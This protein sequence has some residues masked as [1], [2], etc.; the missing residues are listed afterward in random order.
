MDTASAAQ[1]LGLRTT[2]LSLAERR[3]SVASAKASPFWQG[4]A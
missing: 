4:Y 3:G 2:V 1:A